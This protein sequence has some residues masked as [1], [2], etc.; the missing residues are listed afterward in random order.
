MRS[1]NST[2]IGPLVSS[3]AFIISFFIMTIFFCRFS[4]IKVNIA[5]GEI[6]YE[7]DIF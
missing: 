3:V 1:G 7:T 4:Y 2:N 5:R 6:R